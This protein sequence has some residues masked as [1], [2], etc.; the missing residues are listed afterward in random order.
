MSTSTYHPDP[1][2]NAEVALDVRDGEKANLAAG[3]PPSTWMCECGARHSRGHYG[4]IGVHRCMK[5]GYVG[6]GG[7]LL[8][9]RHAH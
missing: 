4:T 8:D 7:V 5:C 1:E 3:L 2:I 6:T 9:S